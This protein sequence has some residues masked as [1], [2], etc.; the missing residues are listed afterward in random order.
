MTKTH[1]NLLKKRIFPS[2]HKEVGV[3]FTLSKKEKKQLDIHLAK[4]ELKLCE[5]YRN[6]TTRELTEAKQL[7]KWAEKESKK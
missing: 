1:K 5:W 2:R 7:D 3:Y 6:L 4:N